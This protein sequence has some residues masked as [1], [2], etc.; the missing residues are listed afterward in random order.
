MLLEWLFLLNLLNLVYSYSNLIHKNYK[1]SLYTSVSDNF[2]NDYPLFPTSLEELAE[3]AAFS[4]KIGLMSKLTRMRMDF[5]LRLILRDRN[6]LQFLA[7]FAANLL[8][9]QS[10]SVH[11]FVEDSTDVI[12][13]SALLE[14]LSQLKLPIKKGDNANDFNNFV[15]E[16]NAALNIKECINRIV[17]SKVTKI[18]IKKN[19]K[20][21]NNSN[22]DKNSNKD[23][24]K[25]NNN[26]NDN[27]N[28]D[29]DEK[30]K[31]KLASCTIKFKNNKFTSR[32]VVSIMEEIEVDDEDSAVIIYEPNNLQSSHKDL[33]ELVEGICFHGALKK[34]PL[35]MINP[36]L[37]STAWNDYGVQRPFL[38]GDF[39]QIYYICDDYFMLSRTRFCGVVQ[40]AASG[41]ELYLLDGLSKRAV[42]PSRIQRL[43]SWPDSASP[44]NMRSTL[45]SVLLRDPNFPLEEFTKR[46]EDRNYYG[47]T[48]TTSA[49]T[50]TSRSGSGEKKNDVTIDRSKK[51][52]KK[53]PS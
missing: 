49:T 50:A 14:Q 9:E 31:M 32:V 35:L 40:R 38:L 30:E 3:D 52:R 17:D 25:D 45:G 4:Y 19:E 29:D 47:R 15:L 18:T 1:Y 21:V 23:N 6:S 8:D 5:N 28:D 44:D 48:T 53:K 11:I 36:S 34:I 37:Y 33:L 2:I 46:M 51:I 10:K 27:N 12:R 39:S 20:E 7:L 42:K 24:N 16:E 41:T 26:N 43:D 13:L 22:I